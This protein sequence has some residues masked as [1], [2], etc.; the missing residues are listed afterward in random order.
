VD[1]EFQRL[2]L[3]GLQALGAGFCTVIWFAYRDGKAKQEAQQAAF[4]QYKLEA[5]T[6]LD[7]AQKEM[8]AKLTDYQLHAAEHFV[9]ANAFSKA[10]EGITKSIDSM[11]QSMDKKLDRIEYKLDGKQDKGQ[12]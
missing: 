11:G 12:S 9:T 2:I 4:A 5:A 7:A 8:Q 1:P 6:S 10:V 3:W